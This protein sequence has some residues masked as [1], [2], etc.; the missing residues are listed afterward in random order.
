MDD[1]VN[2]KSY[3]LIKKIGVGGFSNVYEVRNK[4]D[5]KIY[6]MKVVNKVGVDSED[7]IKQV[8]TEKHIFKKI[9]FPFIVKLHASF[10]T[11]VN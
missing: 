3:Q 10:Q 9:D 5:G 2:K 1:N 7:R 11:V 6:A 8:T 4:F